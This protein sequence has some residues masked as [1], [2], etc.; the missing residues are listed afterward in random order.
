LKVVR[1]TPP[2]GVAP[3]LPVRRHSCRRI[4][5]ELWPYSTMIN[6]RIARSQLTDA[7]SPPLGVGPS[8]HRLNQ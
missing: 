3:G 1:C 5:M 4:T 6:L 8:I 7:N 2:V